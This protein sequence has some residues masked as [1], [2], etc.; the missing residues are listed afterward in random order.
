[1]PVIYVVSLTCGFLGFH[2][3]SWRALRFQCN[4]KCAGYSICRG[5]RHDAQSKVQ[6]NQVRE[7][8]DYWQGS[9]L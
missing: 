5:L 3:R 7:A 9:R 2:T 8:A 6:L 1:M 4:K